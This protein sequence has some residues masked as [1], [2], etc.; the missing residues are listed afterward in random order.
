MA[1]AIQDLCRQLGTMTMNSDYKPYV[2]VSLK[3]LAMI[4]GTK[5]QGRH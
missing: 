4:C 5:L 2:L 1:D 3:D